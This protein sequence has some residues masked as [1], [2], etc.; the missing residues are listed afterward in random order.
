MILTAKSSDQKLQKGMIKGGAIFMAILALFCTSCTGAILLLLR[1][2]AV[3][4]L[5]FSQSAKF[6]N[7][8][9]VQ[10]NLPSE[11]PTGDLGSRSTCQ[12]MHFFP[13]SI[14]TITCFKST[15]TD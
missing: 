5:Y 6:E 9:I 12:S 14:I 11:G 4:K 15:Q 3:Y 8:S 10:I 7:V 13:Q 2:L 1:F